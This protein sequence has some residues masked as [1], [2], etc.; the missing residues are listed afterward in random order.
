M[1]VVLKLFRYASNLN[2]KYYDDHN[3][4]FIQFNARTNLLR[5]LILHNLTCHREE[6]DINQN[7]TYT[8]T[9]L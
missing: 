2:I 7:N 8:R 3:N 4:T 1:I 6:T 5:I 9:L